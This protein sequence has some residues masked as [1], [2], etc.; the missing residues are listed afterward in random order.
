LAE[1]EHALAKMPADHRRVVALK[2]VDRGVQAGQFAA[3]YRWAARAHELTATDDLDQHL[4][5][6]DRE[7]ALP[8]ET[9]RTGTYAA[10]DRA[11]SRQN[12][13]KV[14]DEASQLPLA[15]MAAV[16]RLL[17]VSNTFIDEGAPDAALDL[18][19]RALDAYPRESMV[20]WSLIRA[21]NALGRH[22]EAAD[23]LAVLESLNSEATDLKAA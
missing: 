13:Q 20:Y 19:E 15:E 5:I 1:L 10:F 8:A 14:Y 22:A 2:A 16:A 17:R 9:T 12:W 6:V 18:L 21:L 4:E 7:F 11:V 3:A 23:A